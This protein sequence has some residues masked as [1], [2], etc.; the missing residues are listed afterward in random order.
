MKYIQEY[1]EQI[2]DEICGAKDYAEKYVYYKAKG[3]S[4]RASKYK[5]MSNDELKHA[6]YIHDIAMAD[7]DMLSS[8]F[9]PPVDMQDAWDASHKGYVERVAWVKQMLSM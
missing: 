8:T 1:V 2:D 5:E 4:N 7:I 3:D 9:K 6:T